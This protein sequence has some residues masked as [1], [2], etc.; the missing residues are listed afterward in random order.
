MLSDGVEGIPRKK[1]FETDK[2]D[3]GPPQYADMK[4]ELEEISERIDI[5]YF[6]HGNSALV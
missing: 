6:D 5:Y 1:S 4:Q 2:V 3:I